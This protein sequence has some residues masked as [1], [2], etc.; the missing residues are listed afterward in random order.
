MR[1]AVIDLGTNS[2]RFD[3]HELKPGQPVL[4]LHRE[5]LMIRLGQGVFLNGT[6]DKSAM[7]R[8]LHA[9]VA[10]KRT[11]DSLRATKTIAFATSAMREASD[12]DRFAHIVRKRTGIDIRVISGEEEAKFIA[13]GVLANEKPLKGRYA[14]VDIG[15][16]STEI[17]V[18]RGR[19]V[20][21]SHS[22]QLGTARLQQVFL[23]KSPPAPESVEELR[24]YIRSTLHLKMDAENWGKATRIVGSSGTIRAL[25][26]IMRK[27]RGTA[28]VR[29]KDLKAV[30]QQMRGLSTRELLRIPGMES[31]RVDM[32]LGGAVLLEECMKACGADRA[33]GTEFSLRDGILEEERELQQQQKSSPLSFHVDELYA[34]ARRF[35]ADLR[36]LEQVVRLSEELFDRLRPLHRL[37]SGWR[38]YLTA[39]TILRNVGEKVS[40]IRPEQHSHYIVLN[41]D[42]PTSQRWEQEFVAALC[43]HHKG[44]RAE[45]KGLSF[46]GDKSRMTALG[47]LLA[48]LQVVDALDSGRRADLR[49]GRVQISSRQVRIRFSGKR[50]T[51][52]EIPAVELR[53]G[54]FEK[55]FRRHLSVEQG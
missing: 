22:F 17:S 32:I 47:K 38:I 15:G 23:K 21:H 5:K 6:L 19:E 46:K 45:R 36:H 28:E 55:I 27:T 1:L 26:R 11:A 4:T 13:L 50:A 14:L 35:G 25:I 39:A 40:L 18:C 29:R 37:K 42:F 54:Y 49:I 53:R 12:R 33:V 31:R 43:L 7:R 20:L 16:G 24:S 44:G 8:A 41:A 3:V 48:I 34:L 10:F 52:L 2:V 51:G 9:F 30:I